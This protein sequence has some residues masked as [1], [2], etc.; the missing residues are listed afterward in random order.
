MA[1]ERILLATEMLAI[2]RFR[3]P[4]EDARWRRENWI[5]PRHH[6][7][8][9]ARSVLIEQVGREPI[10]AD[11]NHVVL[12]D[13]GQSYHRELVSPDGDVATYLVASE[14]L[15]RMLLGAG[16]G[17]AP[18]FGRPQLSIAAEPFL[19]IQLLVAGIAAGTVEALEAEEIALGVLDGILGPPSATPTA[20]KPTHTRPDP[21]RRRTISEH[22]RLVLDARRLLV[23]RFAEPLSLA[24]IGRLVGASPYHLAR[25]FRS[26]TGQSLHEYREQIRLRR[27]LEQLT[28]PGRTVGLAAL[29]AEVGF[30]SHAY[31]DTRFRRTFGRA[32]RDVRDAVLLSRRPARTGA[33]MRDELRTI[34]KVGVP[35]QT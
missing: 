33:A 10:L 14:A 23:E 3:C 1:T 34:A 17:R 20:V 28:G 12:Y 13:P 4:P 18:Q 11:P 15:V 9:P 30:G 32:P 26:E 8:F 6:V 21:A 24:E 27:V 22:R 16:G 35:L 5:G 25:L 2:G 31:F 19:R 29:A 7:V